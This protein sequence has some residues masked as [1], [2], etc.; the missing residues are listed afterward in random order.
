MP[1]REQ[2]ILD[3]WFG[4]L[5][6]QTSLSMDSPR[7][8]KWFAGGKQVDEEIRNLFEGDVRKAA[9]GEY[10]AWKRNPHSRLALILLLDQFP[11]HLFRESS[12]SFSYDDKAQ[13][14]CVKGIGE[15]QDQSLSMIERAFFYL[16]LMHAEDLHLQNQ[17]LVQYRVL[18]DKARTQ[19]PKNEDY[20]FMTLDYALKHHAVIQRFGRF[21]HRNQM[22]RRESTSEEL[23]YLRGPDDF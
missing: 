7:A 5:D 19:F 17:S 1:N 11:R 6:D 23:D 18:A 21:P 4:D 13:D 12:Q 14:I 2:E 16:P 20:Y 8:K 3:Y 22:L 10:A 9:N 15:K